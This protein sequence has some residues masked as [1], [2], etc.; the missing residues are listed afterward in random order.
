MV[1][2]YLISDVSAFEQV[3]RDAES[4]FD[5]TGT[6]PGPICRIEPAEKFW[7]EDVTVAGGDFWPNLR[8]LALLHGD[9]HVEILAVEPDP[10]TYFFDFF[11][12]YSAVRLSVEVTPDDYND[13]LWESP[14][15]YADAIRHAVRWVATGPSNAWGLW[16]DRN[17]ELA[18]LCSRRATGL[19]DWR[20]TLT[21]QPFELEDAEAVLGLAFFPDDAPPEI[22]HALRENW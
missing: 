4:V 15:G 18:V 14:P 8:D 9:S 11:E 19:A 12:L 7:F 20:K 13:A 17:V 16:F 5:I 6:F 21:V 2:R 10:V 22:V 1:G 3:R